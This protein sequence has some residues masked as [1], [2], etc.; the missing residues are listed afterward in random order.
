MTGKRHLL[1][2]V[3]TRLT[4]SHTLALALALGAFCLILF[5]LYRRDV[6]SD[7]DLKLRGQ[8]EGVD[9]NL[10]GVLGGSRVEAAASPESWL[11][12]V[13]DQKGQRLFT[14]GIPADE[15]LG[16]L[17][18]ACVESGPFNVTVAGDLRVRVFC[19]KS[20]THSGT[21]ILR[22][23]RIREREADQLNAFARTLLLGVPLVLL[24]SAF[25]GYFLARRALGPVARLTEAARLI[26]ASRLS[27]R[28]PVINQDDELG[29]LATTFNE[30]FQGL[31]QSFLQ[32]RRFT[33]DASHELRT[34]LTAIR[35]MGEVA[36]R[37]RS[38]E[39]DPY[40]TISSMLE[41][42]QHLQGLCESLLLLSRADAGQLLLH[43]SPVDLKALAER[44]VDHIGVLSE[45]K[46]QRLL[47]EIPADLF[48]DADVQLVKQALGNL[49]D[50]AIKFSPPGTTVKVTAADTGG[51]VQIVVTDEGPGIDAKHLPYI[52]E[53][54]Y[55]VDSARGRSGNASG[56][57]LGLAITH[58]ILRLHGGHVYA[59]SEP[60]KG[61]QFT[62]EFPKGSF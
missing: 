18:P 6:Y 49:I 34:P 41:E 32:M 36:L 5:G 48:V 13:W 59:V 54:F 43:R 58:W 28:L 33:S 45:E 14:S 26:T 24:M 30:V 9:D 10:D 40:E 35:T 53:R 2:N 8:V 16:R 15:P 23:A 42:A 37:A 47:A 44:L 7:L 1:Q 39:K 51:A 19:Q 31:E 20:V 62:L 25:L 55:R 56:V 4:A 38:A 50:N 22:G 52:F 17:D 29:R 60:G 57:G 46:E 21:V 12:E 3:R 61:C 11:T 27:E